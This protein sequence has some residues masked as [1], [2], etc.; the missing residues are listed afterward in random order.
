MASQED[1]R[2]IYPSKITPN[3]FGKHFNERPRPD[4]FGRAQATPLEIQRA[5]QGEFN[6]PIEEPSPNPR[7]RSEKNP[8]DWQLLKQQ[9]EQRK[10]EERQRRCRG[11]TTS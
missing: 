8:T 4:V 11:N 6:A 3:I 7:G 2:K 5:M 9:R 10:K 1:L